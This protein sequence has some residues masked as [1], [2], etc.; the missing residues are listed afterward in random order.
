MSQ[1]KTEEKLSADARKPARA[2]V[3]LHSFY[4]GRMQTMAKCVVHDIAAPTYYCQLR[5]E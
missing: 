3:R 1:R 5:E 2:A 4:R